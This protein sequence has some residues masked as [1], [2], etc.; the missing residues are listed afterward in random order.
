GALLIFDEVLTGFRIAPGG[1]QELTGVTPD[2]TVMAKALG[3][4]YPVAAVGGS[5]EVMALAAEGRTLH[6]GTYNSNAL[7]CAAVIAAAAETGRSGFYADLNARGARLAD[8][9][10]AAAKAAGLDACWSGV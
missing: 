6:G 5:G 10:V 1:A 8:G 9:L 7:V 2:L 3:A 4:G